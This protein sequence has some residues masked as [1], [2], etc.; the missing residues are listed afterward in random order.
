VEPHP[1]DRERGIDLG[2]LP[3]GV[4]RYPVDAGLSRRP[5]MLR[6]AAMM[7]VMS[8][9]TKLKIAAD[10]HYYHSRHKDEALRLI[11]SMTSLAGRRQCPTL[12]KQCDEY[13]MDV[14]GSRKY[15]PWLKAYSVFSGTFK[16]GWI[17]DNYYGRVVVPR[18]AGSY[19]EISAYKSISSRL[20]QTDLLPDLAYSTNGLTHTPAMELIKPSELKGYLF[21]ASDRIVYKVD[22]GAQGASV[23][24]YDQDGFPDDPTSFSNGVFQSYIVQHP[25]FDA[26]DGQSVSTIRITTVVDDESNVSCRASYLRL[27]RSADT[28]VKSATAVKVAVNANGELHEQG[29]LPNW[30]PVA[31]H[32]DS[33][34]AFAHQIVPNFE[35]CVQT[36][37]SLHSK[38]LF[39]RMI[40]WDVILDKN[41]E[42]K[43]M[44]WNGG[45]NDIKFSEATIGPCFADLGWQNLWKTPAEER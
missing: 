44:E 37:V 2:R 18:L 4:P 31:Q 36:C 27:P 35:A 6:Y 39:S 17:P 38:M 33:K 3:P 24:V 41:A 26:F 23:F 1:P 28:H 21:G 14:L 34:R 5:G 12:F 42:V 22:S 40:G 30:V 7:S 9:G 15:S 45:H 32:P 8:Y 43:L 25:F 20:F 29:Y 10:S 16:E 13:A 19:G 11:E